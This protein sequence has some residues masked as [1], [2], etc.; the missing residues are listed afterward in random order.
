MSHISDILTIQKKIDAITFLATCGSPIVNSQ[1]VATASKTGWETS[2]NWLEKF[3]KE[4]NPVVS[5]VSQKDTVH[6]F[7]NKNMRFWKVEQKNI[8]LKMKELVNKIK[9]HEDKARKEGEIY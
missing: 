3:S 7:F 8:K 2:D 4:K 5:K 6:L 1:Q 9:E